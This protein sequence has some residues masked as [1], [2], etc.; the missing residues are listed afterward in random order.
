MGLSDVLCT[1]HSPIQRYGNVRPPV[2]AGSLAVCLG[3][4][5]QGNLFHYI[6]TISL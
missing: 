1:Y 6:H 3:M 4:L 5:E 2:S